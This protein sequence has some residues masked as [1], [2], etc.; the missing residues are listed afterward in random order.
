MPVETIMGKQR[1][2][3]K[4]QSADDEE[5][6]AESGFYW[7]EGD[8]VKVL[9][10]RPLEHAGFVNGFSTRLGGV[11]QFPENSLNLAGFDEDTAENIHENRRRFLLFFEGNFKLA[12]AWQ[13]HGDGVKIVGTDEDIADCEG[14]FDGLVSKLPDTLLGV[15][16]ADCVP[17][18]IGDPETGSYAAIH[19]GWRGTVKSIAAKAVLKLSETYGSDPANMIAAIG[20]AAG[21]KNYEIG[22]DVIDAFDSIFSTGGK[23]FTPTRES[24][25]LI[26]LHL[27][28]KDQ[29]IS[30]GVEP[31]NIHTA[32]FCTMTRTD[33]FFSYRIEKKMYGKTGRLMSVIGRY[34]M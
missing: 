13:V 17:V 24:H 23:Y 34:C 22:Q 21:C 3:S 18:L 25:A 31:A 26:D 8:G 28:N 30:S 29:L 10:C 14:K 11:S 32:P 16:T 2:V 4:E 6:L 1:V 15:K 20:P 5:T 9:A 33:L 7:R 27:A 12:T 19:A